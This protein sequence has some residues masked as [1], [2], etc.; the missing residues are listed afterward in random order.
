MKAAL[1]LAGALALAGCTPM[2]Y[3]ALEAGV[4]TTGVLYDAI[5]EGG[6]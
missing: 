6:D 3:V 4:I 2:G 5:T 1:I